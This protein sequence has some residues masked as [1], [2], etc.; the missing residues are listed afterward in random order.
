MKPRPKQLD[1]E[2]EQFEC[3]I[4]RLVKG[5]ASVRSD[6]DKRLIRELRRENRILRR[7]IASLKLV[8]EHARHSLRIARGGSFNPQSRNTISGSYKMVEREL[9]A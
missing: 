4:A 9:A 3:A 1:L 7:K 6:I 8:M 2:L 5:A